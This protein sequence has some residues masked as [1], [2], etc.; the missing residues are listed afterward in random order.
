MQIN[1]NAKKHDYQYKV[2]ANNIQ[3]KWGGASCMRH[4]LDFPVSTTRRLPTTSSAPRSCSVFVHRQLTLIRRPS[5]RL[6]REFT[7][8]RSQTTT[9]SFGPHTTT[10][11]RGVSTP[12]IP[13]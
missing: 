2:N 13:T 12:H 10:V 11:S 1:I 9:A 3:H 4:T 6:T 5:P 7:R 8:R